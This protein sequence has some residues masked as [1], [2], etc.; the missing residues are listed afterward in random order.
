MPI[1]VI[2]DDDESVI[3]FKASLTRAIEPESIPSTAFNAPSNRFVTIPVMDTPIILF[4]LSFASILKLDEFISSLIVLR[5]LHIFSFLYITLHYTLKKDCTQLQNC[6]QSLF[7]LNL[8]HPAII[9]EWG[10]Y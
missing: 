6:I 9:T 5:C 1:I 2:S 8:E 7:I 4:L 10:L 3:L